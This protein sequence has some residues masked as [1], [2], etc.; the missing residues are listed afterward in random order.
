MFTGAAAA[1]EPD[2]RRS[3]GASWVE[4]LASS[5]EGHSDGVRRSQRSS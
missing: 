1:L 4:T 3:D 2:E 5:R